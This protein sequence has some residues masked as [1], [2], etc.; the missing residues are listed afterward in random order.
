MSFEEQIK[1]WVSLDNQ[2]KTL[3]ERTKQLRNER[4]KSE[5]NILEYVET[6]QLKNTTVNIS[7]GKLRFVEA[8]QTAPLTLKYVEEC[9]G[10]CINNPTHIMSIMNVI[11]NSRETKVI[12]DIK[13]YGK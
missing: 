1:H 9:L 3:A 6:S 4:N 12:M 5:E 11:K 8:K 2:L 7:D 13:R 10:K